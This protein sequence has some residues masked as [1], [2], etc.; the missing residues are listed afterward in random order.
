[1]KVAQQK[2]KEADTKLDKHGRR[3][4]GEDAE[5]YGDNVLIVES[6]AQPGD[7]GTSAPA[8]GSNGKKQKSSLFEDE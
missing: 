5:L 7:E 1:M 8:P 6:A 3:L 2:T 4:E